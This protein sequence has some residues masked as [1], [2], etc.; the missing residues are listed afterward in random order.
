MADA[1]ATRT[2]P[3][4]KVKNKSPC[5]DWISPG[6]V[7]CSVLSLVFGQRCG[8]RCIG[9]IR[10][11]LACA[12]LPNPLRQIAFAKQLWSHRC[13]HLS[14]SRLVTPLALN[15]EPALPLR[16]GSR[17]ALTRWAFWPCATRWAFWP[18]AACARRELAPGQACEN[19][20]RPAHAGCLPTKHTHTHTHTH[21]LCV[22]VKT[23][24]I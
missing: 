14:P 6:L 1:A 12:A 4:L 21:T 10:A 7:T 22:R 20:W 18:C 24:L 9:K 15:P 8:Q 5:G 16:S 17:N 19:C 11:T 3:R 23:I 2:R 13:R